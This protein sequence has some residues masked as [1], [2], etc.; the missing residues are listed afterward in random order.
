MHRL[1]QRIYDYWDYIYFPGLRRR[2]AG[3]A[4]LV[5]AAIVVAV[6]LYRPPLS[7]EVEQAEPLIAT[8]PDSAYALLTRVEP[9]V[10]DCS[11]SKATA[12][13]FICC[14]PKPPTRL[15]RNFPPTV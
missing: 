11:E 7:D 9:E 1:W 12:C 13:G 8:H 14:W 3:V 5:V 2:I 10:Q 15:L 4:A 6:C